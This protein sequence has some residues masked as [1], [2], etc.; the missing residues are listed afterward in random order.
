MSSSYLRKSA[1]DSHRA[2][3]RR[4]D[5][6]KGYSVSESL[7]TVEL[8]HSTELLDVDS[9]VSVE[10][11]NRL[12]S[13]SFSCSS[14]APPPPA[15]TPSTS[16]FL[17]SASARLFTN[18]LTSWCPASEKHSSVSFASLSSS[19]SSRMTSFLAATAAAR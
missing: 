17:V 3:L 2:E 15:T 5:D 8:R 14:R 18:S 16:S 7:V 1:Y 19:S 12:L 9:L 6:E 4:D 13:L 10:A 11:P